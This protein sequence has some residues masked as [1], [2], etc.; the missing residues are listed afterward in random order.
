MMD[1]GCF[2]VLVPLRHALAERLFFE[3]RAAMDRRRTLPRAFC[4]VACALAGLVSGFS[5][6]V[7]QPPPGL[8]PQRRQYTPVEAAF[9]TL[10]VNDARRLAEIDMQLGLNNRM[11]M[12][13]WY[14]SYY[15]GVFEPW[16]MVPGGI[17]GYP[18]LNPV[19]QS[20]GQRSYQA[21][22]NRWISEPV[23]ADQIAPAAAPVAGPV[24]AVLPRAGN[25]APRGPVELPAPRPEPEDE[26]AGATV[27][28]GPA[29]PQ[30]VGPREF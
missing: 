23:Y 13:S 1:S 9:D 2:S 12:T 8:P 19:R 18:I 22:P 7:A 25:A 20:I 16:P 28:S 14:G 27:P 24:G 11:R 26:P 3:G 4:A 6:A 29:A 30:A 15:R 10:Y 17:W 5:V 21:S